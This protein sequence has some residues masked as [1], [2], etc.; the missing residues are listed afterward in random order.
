Y[1]AIVRGLGGYAC[2]PTDK[3]KRCELSGKEQ[4]DEER[5]K[6]MCPVCYLFGCGGWKRKF[7]LEVRNNG[8]TIPFQL[9]TLDEDGK[10]NHRWLSEISEEMLSTKMPFGDVSLNFKI[11]GGRDAVKQQLKALLSIMA[12]IGGIGAKTQ[13]GFGQFDWEEKMDLK[14]AINTIRDFLID[15]NF[16]QGSNENKWNS[17][18]KYWIYEIKLPS[19]NKLVKKFKKANVIGS[20]H[21]PDDYLPVSFDI[22]YKLPDSKNGLR[23]GYYLS[24]EKQKG[25]KDAKRETRDIFGTLINDKVGSRVFVSHLF[26]K[27][28]TD[29]NYWLRVWGFTE[30]SVCVVVGEELKKMFE[31]PNCPSIRTGKAIIS[32]SEVV[33]DEF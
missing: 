19:K 33:S 1:E 9:A 29:N 5:R 26:K 13:Y 3:D 24:I 4:T 8:E 17:L 20:G 15:N 18:E 6:N 11:A 7:R 22:R 30:D 23:E 14:E 12:H 2:D 32:R 31:L 25:K 16:K 21:L 10:F 28:E 27:G